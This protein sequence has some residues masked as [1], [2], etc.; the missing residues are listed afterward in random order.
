MLFYCQ[1]RMNWNL[2]QI[3]LRSKWCRLA[4]HTADE[5][6]KNIL[7]AA[8]KHQA[9]PEGCARQWTYRESR[10]FRRSE[11]W[12][13]VSEAGVKNRNGVSPD[14]LPPSMQILAS[15]SGPPCVVGRTSPLLTLS[16]PR[17][18]SD[19]GKTKLCSSIWMTKFATAFHE[20]EQ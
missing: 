10:E 11:C 9:L 5:K 1:N 7:V 17:L 4:I 12:K 20:D 18:P 14:A 16:Y 2:G 3:Y 19:P 8:E 6:Y 15:A 13:S